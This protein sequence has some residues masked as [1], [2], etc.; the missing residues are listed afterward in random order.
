MR[1]ALAIANVHPGFGTCTIARQAEDEGEVEGSDD[2]VDFDI[3]ALPFAGLE[4]RIARRRKL[5][6]PDNDDQRGLHDGNPAQPSCLT[7]CPATFASPSQNLHR[8]PTDLL[9][10]LH[11]IPASTMQDAFR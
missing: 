6:E 10:T 2:D 7:T 4:G 3:G 1:S 9:S 8:S 11:N 5:D